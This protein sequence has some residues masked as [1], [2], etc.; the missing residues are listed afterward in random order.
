MRE[1]RVLS[2]VDAPSWASWPRS[3]ADGRW[4]PHL[5]EIRGALGRGA[6]TDPGPRGAATYPGLGARARGTD[7]VC[8]T[9]HGH[10]LRRGARDRGSGLGARPLSRGFGARARGTATVWGAGSEHDAVIW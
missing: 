3:C 1:W 8:G 9:G 10:G 2:V 4:C 6:A 7:T 5:A